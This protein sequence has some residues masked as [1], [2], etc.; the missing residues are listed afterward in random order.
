MRHPY[1]IFFIFFYS[2]K[3]QVDNF[4][5]RKSLY[6]I[7]PE[8]TAALVDWQG[9]CYDLLASDLMWA[10]YGFMKNLPDKVTTV[11]TFLVGSLHSID[12]RKI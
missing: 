5:F 9:A 11:D 8:F 7:E 4:L 2:F 1:I 3:F 6:S 10:L 12:W